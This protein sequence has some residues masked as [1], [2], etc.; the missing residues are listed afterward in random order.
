MRVI[1][2]GGG[3]IG[4][5]TAFY[6]NARGAQVLL[7]EREGDV[8]R[9]TSKGNAGVISPGCV[10]PWAAPGMPLKILKYLWKPQSPLIYRPQWNGRQWMWVRRWL[11]E[12]AAARFRVNKQRMQRIAYYS[13]RCLAEFRAAHEMEY[14]RTQGF[15]QV[16]RSEFDLH[17]AQPGI[18]VLE[19]AGIAHSVLN[20]DASF[21]VEPSLRWAAVKPVAA[22]HLPDDETG[23]CAVFASRL[24]TVC[25]AAGVE[26]LF[27][28]DVSALARLGNCVD[29]VVVRRL[30]GELSS[31]SADAVV[32]A[33]GVDSRALLAPLGIEL[34]L[35]P[36]KGYSATLP[37]KDEAKVLR[38]AVMD[39]A[40]KIG[41]TRMGPVVRVAGTAELG[42]G[43]RALR[44]KATATL[45]KVVS[46]WFPEGVDLKADPHFW[47]GL[48]PMTPDGPP[49]LGATPLRNLYL[50]AGHGSTGWAMAMGSG[51]V[52]AD[53][54]TGRVPD[55]DLSGLTLERYQ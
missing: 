55:I 35:Y 4:L 5:A 21:D 13:Q 2:I 30:D 37:V 14:W 32:V 20:G 29:G 9:M 18:R 23:D 27:D 1:V 15:L 42:D 12:C 47:V 24:R 34:P 16:Y 8:A 51:R 25:E 43:I 6:L 38:A 53:I 10:T 28:T 49:V 44:A 33:G 46:D 17:M 31:L 11:G 52:V 48:R 41:M 45:I 22:L 7:I 19:E 3:I 26:F 36:V 50:N 39:E 54:T 40:L